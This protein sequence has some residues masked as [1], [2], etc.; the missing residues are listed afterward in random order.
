MYEWIIWLAVIVASV[1]VEGATL[2]LV[3]VWFVPGG[4]VALILALLDVNLVIQLI[5]FLAV[6]LAMMTCLRPV[7][8]RFIRIKPVP[9]NSDALIGE[10]AITVEEIDN[11]ASTGAVKIK[12]E[13]WSARSE[14]GEKIA[15]GE[16][17]TVCSIE[18]VKLICKK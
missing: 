6:S 11:L 9:T 3:S 5:V 16:T 2:S 13:T 7:F 10:K 12:G 1:A 18:G 4:I 8:K 15:E 17:V 14:D